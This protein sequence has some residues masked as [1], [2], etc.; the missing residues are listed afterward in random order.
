M[1]THGSLF[2]GI[3]GFD[4][5]AQW[6]GWEN[7]FHCEW[8]EFGQKILKHYWP[9]AISYGDITKT[10]FT[11]HR[12]AIDILTGG[13][14]CQ[15]FSV[16]GDRQG[17]E[18]DRYLW[19]EFLRAVEEIKPRWIVAENVFGLLNIDRGRT[20]ELICSDLENCGYQKPI[21]FD[22][23]ADAFGLQ[24]MERHIWFIS[25]ANG[26]GQQRRIIGENQDFKTP[27]QLPRTDQRELVR[28]DISESRFCDVGERV[29][30]RLDKWGKE[31]VKAGGNA[32]PP[33]AAY[34][35]FRTIEMF[36][37]DPLHS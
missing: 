10:D 4:L 15:P 27:R 33:Q 22:C 7:V 32:I 24:T 37:H 8:N 30:R 36:S 9:D 13:F 11:V 18:D 28:R 3:G 23:T 1:K 16:A 6:M 29:S 31:S 20:P 12:G 35:I 34:Q 25:E 5:A 14:P 26:G 21:I 19:P 2:S 17:K